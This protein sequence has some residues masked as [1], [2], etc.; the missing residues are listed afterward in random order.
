MSTARKPGSYAAWQEELREQRLA[1]HNGEQRRLVDAA[2]ERRGLAGLVLNVQQ[3][4]ALAEEQR[5]VEMSERALVLDP[6][7]LA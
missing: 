5:L 1:L 7:T 6:E 2:V 3:Q 4:Q